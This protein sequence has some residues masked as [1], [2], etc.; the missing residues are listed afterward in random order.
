MIEFKFQ[1]D[2]IGVLCQLTWHILYSVTKETLA[3]ADK[4]PAHRRTIMLTNSVVPRV[5]SEI[6]VVY[7]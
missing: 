3:I 1:G 7:M 4:L 5:V 2:K 6:T